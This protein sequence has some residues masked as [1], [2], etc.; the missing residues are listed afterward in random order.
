MRYLVKT[1]YSATGEGEYYYFGIGNYDNK[2]KA[3]NF[4]FA[5][6]CIHSFYLP[7]VKVYDLDN[8]QEAQ[9]AIRFLKRVFT[10][11]IAENIINSG[12]HN[13]MFVKLYWNMS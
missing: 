9:E 4:F 5:E 10:E 2:T 11:R 12:N 13:D 6:N 8:Q 3:I 7:G 1:E